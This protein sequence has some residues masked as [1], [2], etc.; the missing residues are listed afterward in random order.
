MRSPT[1]PSIASC[2]SLRSSLSLS[3]RR[4]MATLPSAANIVV[5]PNQPP[6]TTVHDGVFESL[7]E[8]VQSKDPSAVHI[9]HRLAS[10]FPTSSDALHVYGMAL[11]AAG[12]LVPATEMILRAVAL[13]PQV[14]FYRTNLASIYLLRG[15]TQEAYES[16]SAS[17]EIEFTLEA[18][19]AILDLVRGQSDNVSL[20]WAEV[21]ASDEMLEQ[22]CAAAED[23]NLELD[24]IADIGG[25]SDSLKDDLSS[26]LK[27]RAALE[28]GSEVSVR[29]MKLSCILSPSPTCLL[30]LGAA[31]DS[32]GAGDDAFELF[33]RGVKGKCMATEP[34]SDFVLPGY[35]AT[36]KTV[37]I[38]C[39]EYGQTWWPNWSYTSHQRGGLGGSEEAVLFVSRELAALGYTVIIYTRIVTVI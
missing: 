33:S 22:L 13:E 35:A 24:S 26:L 21:C 9:G 16:Y 20:A 2:P 36:R 30:Q 37:A 17:L 27:L 28:V 4:I 5:K 12:D 34:R 6:T 31:L 11:K 10:S 32:T 14:A 8:A 39:D 25:V 7:V 38:Y 19:K 15:Q 18:A 3:R 29:L 1:K 23:L